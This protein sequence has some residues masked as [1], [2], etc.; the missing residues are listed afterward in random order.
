MTTFGERIR[1]LRKAKTWTL[2]DLAPKVGVGFTYL[3][4]VENGRLDFGD[5]PSAALIRRLAEALEADEDELLLLAGRV[6]ESIR[7]RLRE[8]PDAFRKLASLDDQTLNQVVALAERS[9]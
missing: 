1:E 8:R 4:K 3:S 5:Y 2:R 7:K 9:G 6:P